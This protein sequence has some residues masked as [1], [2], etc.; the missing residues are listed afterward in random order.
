VKKSELTDIVRAE[1]E[2]SRWRDK[3]TL[4]QRK[5][6]ILQQEHRKLLR[7]QDAA[8]EIA[9]A[10]RKRYKI[11][12]RGRS[13]D[14]SI[15]VLVCSDWH[16]EEEVKPASVG[17]RN[18]YNLD[19]AEKR[20]KTLFSRTLKMVRKEQEATKIDTLI[21]A[22]LGDFIS[23][24]IHDELLES[25][26]LR[27]I[28][29]IIFAQTLI[30]SGIDFLL[31]HSELNLVIPCKC[32]NHSRIS[33][34]VHVANESGNSLEW[35]MYWNLK[36]RYKDNPR[37]TF[38]VEPSYHTF[39]KVYQ[40]TIRFHHGHS[41]RYHGGV[42]GLHI[43]LRKAIS[44]WNQTQHADLDVIGHFHAYEYTTHR[45]IVNGS[46][47]GWSPFGVWIKAVEE[48]P[49]QAFFLWNKKR[50]MKTVTIPILVEV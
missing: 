16:V 27:P 24:N 26:L 49:M 48:P 47:I 10:P 11:T 30:V 43:P 21:V 29:A 31:E 45:Y 33:R 44:Q 19:I 18:K 35:A 42:G 6:R 8:L 15:A 39:V 22:L 12:P 40:D 37:V 5:Y 3:A 46:L 50:R 23:G 2:V 4:A 28:D 34:K 41:I 1:Q 25:C 13:D 7:D 14:E 9:R 36:N 38:I 32:G 20:V 17:Y